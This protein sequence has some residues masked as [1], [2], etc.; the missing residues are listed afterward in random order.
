MKLY[1]ERIL[2]VKF[3]VDSSTRFDA[4][5]PRRSKSEKWRVINE[6]SRKIRLYRVVTCLFRQVIEL[7]WSDN[8]DFQRKNVQSRDNVNKLTLNHKKM[9]KNQFSS[10]IFRTLKTLPGPD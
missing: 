1:T 6:N 5:S 4:Q 2:S 7:S 3:Q 8:F 9:E 10:H